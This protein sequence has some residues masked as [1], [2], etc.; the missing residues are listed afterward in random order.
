MKFILAAFAALLYAVFSMHG[1]GA[2]ETVSIEDEHLL[3]GAGFTYTLQCS[4]NTPSCGG[5]SPSNNTSCT[6]SQVGSETSSCLTEEVDTTCST[7]GG[8]YWV[9]D[10]CDDSDSL[11]CNAPSPLTCQHQSGSSYKWVPN[12]GGSTEGDCGTYNECNEI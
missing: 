8:W 5:G 12:P 1:H 9:F 6:E 2:F 11:D 3:S 4:T 7:L 10:G